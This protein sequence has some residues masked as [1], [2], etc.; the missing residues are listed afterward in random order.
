MLRVMRRP[1][2]ARGFLRHPGQSLDE[3]I[4]RLLNDQLLLYILL[5]LVFWLFAGMQWWMKV[6]A[7]PPQPLVF[8]AAAVGLTGLLAFKFVRIMEQVRRNRLG[9]DGER[10]VA[11]VLEEL[12]K[13]GATVLH[14]IP[15]DGFNIDHVVIS[16]RGIFAIETKTLT[17][18]P[19][20]ERIEFDGRT[21][22]VAGRI[23]ERDP[24]EQCR[25]ERDWLRDLLKR[26]TGRQLPVR[27]VVVFPGWWVER[28]AS[29][30]GSEIWVL[31]PKALIKWVAQAREVISPSDAS[32]A[33]LH[34]EQWVKGR[35]I[36][37]DIGREPAR[38]AA[39]SNARTSGSSSALAP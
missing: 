20:R 39:H 16:T 11:E 29:A 38:P 3:E 25:A 10:E 30:R 14:D 31:N 9:R 37:G 34:L 24:V 35:P 26:S 22:T 6:R 2:V 4:D 23:M 1:P 27:G 18:S 5:A 17:K 7:M 33:S 12:V 15:A 28:A 13:A 36:W 21:V 32:M 8:T 19:S